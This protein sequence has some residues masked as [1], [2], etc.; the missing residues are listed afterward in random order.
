MINTFLFIYF[1]H[2]FGTA[3]RRTY[4]RID[5]ETSDKE[6]T[7]RHANFNHFGRALLEMG[8]YLGHVLECE[9]KVYCGLVKTMY[10]ASFREYFNHP[11]STTDIKK[12][13]MLLR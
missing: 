3:F 6:V 4:H 8:Q 9:R 7:E 11:L 12:V 5:G 1:V 2:S 10:F 13:G